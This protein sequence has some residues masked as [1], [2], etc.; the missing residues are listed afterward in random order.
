MTTV[1]W[2]EGSDAM[3]NTGDTDEA[4]VRALYQQLI[5]GWNAGSSECFAAPFTADGDLVAFDGLHFW[6]R[7]QIAAFQQ[8]LFDKWMKGSCLVGGVEEVRFLSPDV[9]VMH[10][11][12]T[13]WRAARPSRLGNGPRSRPWWRCGTKGSGA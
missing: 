11:L 2:T 13:P 3:D 12:G 9:A 6:G 10:A 1:G 5:D 8:Q 7:E 4:A